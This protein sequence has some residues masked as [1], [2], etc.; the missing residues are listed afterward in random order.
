VPTGANHQSTPSS[1]AVHSVYRNS[2]RAAPAVLK[3]CFKRRLVERSPPICNGLV[4]EDSGNSREPRSDDVATITHYSGWAKY[5]TNHRKTMAT[6][7]NTS[8]LQQRLPEG[9]QWV[10]DRSPVGRFLHGRRYA[11]VDDFNIVRDPLKLIQQNGEG[12]FFSAS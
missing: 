3:P 7:W 9:T 12:M 4:K 10:G 1:S 2:P 6:P 8:K 11:R 5:R